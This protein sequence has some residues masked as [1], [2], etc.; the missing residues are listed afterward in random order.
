MPSVSLSSGTR[1]CN[2]DAYECS[3]FDRAYTSSQHIL[4]SF[5]LIISNFEMMALHA[6][7]TRQMYA[8]VH[9]S[10]M[11][12]MA[13]RPSIL[14]RHAAASL[15]LPLPFVCISRRHLVIFSQIYFHFRCSQLFEFSLFMCFRFARCAIHRDNFESRH[16]THDTFPKVMRWFLN[17]S[18]QAT[19]T[20]RKNYSSPY[21]AYCSINLP[22][23]TW[24]AWLT[25]ASV[26]M[27]TK[28][29]KE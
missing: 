22:I 23:F 4:C 1:V 13:F 2:R 17:A 6:L 3:D 28:K 26:Q 20:N 19:R 7:F 24:V 11:H 9:Y 8:H 5:V 25:V 16:A 21:L 18:M 27:K 10:V 14:A 12:E 29:A 15:Q